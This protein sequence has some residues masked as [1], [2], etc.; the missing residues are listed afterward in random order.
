MDKYGKK[1]LRVIICLMIVLL[2]YL[3]NAPK[4]M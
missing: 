4:A 1:V 3:L 2:I